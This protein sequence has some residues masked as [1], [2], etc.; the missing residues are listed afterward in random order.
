MVNE[1][2]SQ[3]PAM[4][5][6]HLGVFSTQRN[7]QLVLGSQAYFPAVQY[8]S[9]ALPSGTF[10]H[11][12]ILKQSSSSYGREDADTKLPH[13]PLDVNSLPGTGG[14]PN[15]LEQLNQ[16]EPM[17][18]FDSPEHF[19][20]GPRAPNHPS[21]PLPGTLAGS[22]SP[23][24][25]LSAHSISSHYQHPGPHHSQ[26]ADYNSCI[27][28]NPNAFS[29]FNQPAHSQAMAAHP[30]P[31]HQFPIMPP[32][33]ARGPAEGRYESS[34]NHAPPGLHTNA[35]VGG[36]KGM[37]IGDFLSGVN[38]SHPG[39]A[40]SGPPRSHGGH[41][42]TLAQRHRPD[43]ASTL[44]SSIPPANHAIHS[45]HQIS[46]THHYQSSHQHHNHHQQPMDQFSSHHPGP[47]LNLQQQQ[48]QQIHHQSQPQPQQQQHQH[49]SYSPTHTKW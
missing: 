9:G 47:P 7:D 43:L 46:P 38:G 14:A 36:D 35:N 18:A 12:L 17:Q 13:Q 19:S 15:Q 22:Q 25:P 23:P 2:R 4:L 10:G 8:D 33:S 42:H 24:A 32:G 44:L 6:G 40:A 39:S 26:L 48:Q 1:A 37:D 28:E 41:H 29:Q 5:D 20:G 3:Y 21:W 45:H 30:D 31:F 16:S 27:A 34:E 11:F 49:P